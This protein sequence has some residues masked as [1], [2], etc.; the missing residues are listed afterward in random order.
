MAIKFLHD[1][2]Y[3]GS[4]S[5]L[6]IDGTLTVGSNTVIDTARRGYF[7]S[8]QHSSRISFLNGSQGTTGS[9]AQAIAV[10]R[11]RALDF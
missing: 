10:S 5:D 11:F 6:T 7:A 3:T 1:G 8:I 9:G 4:N 2:H